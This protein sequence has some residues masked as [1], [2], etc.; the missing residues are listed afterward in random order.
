MTNKP[1]TDWPDNPV[2]SDFQPEGKSLRDQDPTV[3]EVPPSYAEGE[4]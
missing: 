1:L 4:E 2:T 3:K